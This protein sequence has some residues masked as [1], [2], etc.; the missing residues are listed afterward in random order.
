MAFEWAEAAAQERVGEDADAVH[1]EQ[2][3]GVADELDV[4]GRQTPADWISR[5]GCGPWP[6]H[7][8]RRRD[9]PLARGLRRS[10]DGCRSSV[11]TPPRTAPAVV[12]MRSVI[13]SSYVRSMPFAPSFRPIHSPI[14]QIPAAA[15]PDAVA[16]PA[17]SHDVRTRGVARAPTTEATSAPS[18]KWMRSSTWARL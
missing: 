5:S 15:A 18:A 11:T 9:R 7:A 4:D 13:V 3:R 1:V 14:S 6:V 16:T 2:N 10:L 8:S 12:S 17:A